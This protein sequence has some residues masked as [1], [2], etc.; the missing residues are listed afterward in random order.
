MSAIETKFENS[1]ILRREPKTFAARLNKFR[2]DREQQSKIMS[3]NIRPV[4]PADAEACG[5]II[6]KAFCGIADRHNF[7]HDFLSREHANG[8]AQMVIGNPAVYGVAAESDGKFVGSNF[9]WEQNEIAGV[10]PITIDPEAQAN[11]AG[12][13]LMQAVIERGKAARGIRLVQDAFNS[14]SM[15]LYTSLG[16]DIKEPLVLIEG[17][18]S[19]SLP[20]GTEVRPVS[21]EDYTA[22]DELCQKIHGFSRLEELRGIAQ[23]MSAFVAVRDNRIVGYAS[24]PNVW[25]MNHAV[26]ET[27]EDMQN[28]LTGA[29]N[30]TAKPLSFLLPTRNGDLF[31]WCLKNGMKVVKPMSLMS[32]GTYD[33]PHGT[34]LTSVLY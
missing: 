9:L 5:Q 34:F 12:R 7:P 24:A 29:A 33:E 21:E 25:Q 10:G 15:S 23:M 19:G 8:L 32:M 14:A 22:C 3:I 16:F 28:L 18:I 13:V 20:E 2:T 27:N 31:R 6:Y 17:A 11:G 1:Y 4:T 30:L 26:A